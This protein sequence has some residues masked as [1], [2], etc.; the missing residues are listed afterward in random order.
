MERDGVGCGGDGGVWRRE[1]EW[2]LQAVEC[3]G[4]AVE[5]APW[6][7]DVGAGCCFVLHAKKEVLGFG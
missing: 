3:S 1:A 5:T 6:V 4:S 7:N 2:G